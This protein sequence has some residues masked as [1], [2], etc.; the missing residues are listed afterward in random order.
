M[1]DKHEHYYRHVH[2]TK[3]ERVVAVDKWMSFDGREQR[4]GQSAM[5]RRVL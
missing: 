5:L 2:A 3:T 4:V 1:P